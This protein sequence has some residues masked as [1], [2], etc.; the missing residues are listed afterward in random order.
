[1][2]DIGAL[3]LTKQG[4]FF[5]KLLV[6]WFCLKWMQGL[7]KCSSRFYVKQTQGHLHRLSDFMWNL[8]CFLFRSETTNGGEH[9]QGVTSRNGQRWILNNVMCL[10]TRTV[11]KKFRWLHLCYKNSALHLARRPTWSSLEVSIALVKT[12]LPCLVGVKL[13]AMIGGSRSLIS[14]WEIFSDFDIGSASLTHYTQYL[15]SVAH[16]IHHQPTQICLVVTGWQLERVPCDTW[17]FT[18]SHKDHANLMPHQT[19][20]I[21]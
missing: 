4:F 3:A 17:C 5:W 15:I 1:M 13:R 11:W 8:F 20:C 2:L 19:R 18:T 14:R 12:L 6:G 7:P 10:S 16:A 9:S 21:V